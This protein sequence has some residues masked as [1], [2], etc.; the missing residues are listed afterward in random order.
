MDD[1]PSPLRSPI[2]PT[3][4][5]CP[6][7]YEWDEKSKMFTIYIGIPH[8]HPGIRISALNLI[9]VW[10]CEQTFKYLDNSDRSFSLGAV[11]TFRILCSA[12][13][14]DF[15]GPT[16][17][18]VIAK[19]EFLPPLDA[20]SARETLRRTRPNNIPVDQLSCL[21]RAFASVSY[22]ELCALVVLFPSLENLVLRGVV[23][24]VFPYLTR[25][26]PPAWLPEEEWAGEI[27]LK[28]LVI[29]LTLDPVATGLQPPCEDQQLNIA[30]VLCPLALFKQV[31]DL[32]LRNAGPVVRQMGDHT[33]YLGPYVT[34]EGTV[35][36]IGI[37]VS[38]I[39]HLH[40]K[41]DH[42]CESVLREMVKLIQG[43]KTGRCL[44]TLEIEK[45]YKVD[46]SALR[47][48]VYRIGGEI[49]RMIFELMDQEYD[50][51]AT[52]HSCGFIYP[53]LEELS[54]RVTQRPK[55]ARP[56][57][58]TLK[59]T[60]RWYA[61]GTALECFVGEVSTPRLQTL[62]LE[63]KWRPEQAHG[64]NSVHALGD[65][66][67]PIVAPAIEKILEP[68]WILGKIHIY[69]I[70][71]DET[72]GCVQESA[73]KELFPKLSMLTRLAAPPM[74]VMHW[75]RYWAPWI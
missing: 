21:P 61:F 19:E 51:G 5:I 14:Q 6:I 3:L 13:R 7:E 39:K 20:A 32:I 56:E 69:G 17:A 45:L 12:V 30:Q 71:P 55:T 62:Y 2:I 74:Q 29:D 15:A 53:H 41:G 18:A 16:A 9:H 46:M 38:C 31:D 70:W 58:M 27:A 65:P 4:P 50:F 64:R 67:V 33:P 49:K 40:I 26:A 37:D 10:L 68:L 1:G 73:A 35:S 59:D 72:P 47:Y 63:V 52:A 36:F 57:T 25:V 22:P 54:L 23:T 24:G 43:D 60:C 28:T 75:H 34:E 8:D 42:T 66:M 48:F 44:E 11:R